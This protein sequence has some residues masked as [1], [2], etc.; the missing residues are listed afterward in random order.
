MSKVNWGVIACADF[1]RRRS[2]PAMLQAPSV[3][4]IAIASRTMDKARAFTAEFRIPRMYGSYEELLMD[5]D[6]EAVHIV[7]PNSLHAEWTLKA[8]EH[9]KHVLCEKPFATSRDQMQAIRLKAEQTGLH[10]MEGFMWRFHPQ[11]EEAASAIRSG[12]IG[13]VVLVRAALSLSIT[14][15]HA[16][17]LDPALGA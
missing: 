3:N 16:S 8:L 12:K 9:G 11:H 1:A 7:T 2:I 6:V 15:R 5:G 14:Q 13:R 17:R 4:L 10:V